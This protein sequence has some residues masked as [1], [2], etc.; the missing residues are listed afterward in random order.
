VESV[1]LADF[2]GGAGLQAL[3]T[4]IDQGL[5][6]VVVSVHDDDVPVGMVINQSPSPNSTVHTGD[7]ITLLV[8]EGPAS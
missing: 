4:V 5:K 7:S 1:T 3:G 6:F 2:R 8:S